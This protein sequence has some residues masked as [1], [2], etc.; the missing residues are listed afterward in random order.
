VSEMIFSAMKAQT[1]EEAKGKL[2]ALVG[3]QGSI[4]SR[5]VGDESKARWEELS[6]RVEEFI[7]GVEDDGLHE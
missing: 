7:R 4:P 3:I 2:R 6:D 5:P 1:W